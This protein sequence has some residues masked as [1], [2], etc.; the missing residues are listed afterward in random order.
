M[1]RT[2]REAMGDDAYWKGLQ[3]YFQ[4]FSYKIARSQD[5]LR[6]LKQAAPQADLLPIYRTYL[7]YSYLKYTNLTANIGGPGPTED[8]WSGQVEVPV[9]VTAD[10]PTYTLSVLLDGAVMTT[11]N[12]A[13]TLT[14]DTSSLANGKHELAAKVDDVGVNHAEASRPFQVSRPTPTPTDT[15]LRPLTPT[16]TI[17]PSPT[18]KPSPTQGLSPIAS[19][20]VTPQPATVKSQNSPW[21]QPVGIA[22]T[23]IVVLGVAL[24]TRRR[25]RRR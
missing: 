23:I 25:G 3:T 14:V 9:S 12:S 16:P 4:Q 2:L 15:P 7:D 6:T 24:A 18:P 1:F 13:I 19:P 21:R 11:T 5:L 22:I 20:I 8:V 17:P 10:S